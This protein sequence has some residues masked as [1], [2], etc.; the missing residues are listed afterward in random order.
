MT[1]ESRKLSNF[2]TVILYD[3]RVKDL[4]QNEVL[5]EIT[6]NLF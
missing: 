5:N 6:I 3:H 1:V 4:L 2:P